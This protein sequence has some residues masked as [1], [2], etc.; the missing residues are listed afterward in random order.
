MAPHTSS[1][2]ERG[3]QRAFPQ[4]AAYMQNPST[5]AWNIATLPTMPIKSTDPAVTTPQDSPITMP[6]QM[7]IL[8]KTRTEVG[9]GISLQAQE[10]EQRPRAVSDGEWWLTLAP[11]EAKKKKK[12]LNNH[13]N[14][15]AHRPGTLGLAS[16][17]PPK[18][19][20]GRQTMARRGKA[21]NGKTTKQTSFASSTEDDV[22]PLKGHKR[23][24]SS[25]AVTSPTTAYSGEDSSMSDHTYQSSLFNGSLATAYSSKLSPQQCL[26]RIIRKADVETLA[27]DLDQ[28]DFTQQE[29]S[30]GIKHAY[31]LLQDQI[32]L[33][34]QVKVQLQEAG[35]QPEAE[36][37]FEE[38]HAFRFKDVR[39]LVPDTVLQ[40]WA[41]EDSKQ[42][43]QALIM[44]RLSVV[45]ETEALRGALRAIPGM[46]DELERKAAY[47]KMWKEG[48]ATVAS[49][50]FLGTGFALLKGAQ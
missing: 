16:S 11:P 40:T 45:K 5:A 4:R 19:S 7:T 22:S 35:W 18:T 31:S 23:D 49:L 8:P 12:K 44:K 24:Y 10:T 41:P 14:G 9:N 46:C 48:L 37:S 32:I 43:I 1:P 36:E 21:T 20:T 38:C 2:G 15:G 6:Q 25:D 17:A 13:A 34:A 33:R 29:L 3:H 27:T 42:A 50:L 47:R 39:D 30:A 28:G 26:N